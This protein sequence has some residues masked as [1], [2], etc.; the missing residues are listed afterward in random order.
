MRPDWEECS[1]L[2]DGAKAADTAGLLNCAHP[3]CARICAGREVCWPYCLA[4]QRAH[5]QLGL[6]QWVSGS[7]RLDLSLQYAMYWLYGTVQAVASQAQAIHLKSDLPRQFLCMPTYVHCVPQHLLC[8][9][10]ST[11]ICV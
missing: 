5:Y 3:V 10:L 9:S 6:L 7:C 4:D 8:I 1:F 11:S 2:W